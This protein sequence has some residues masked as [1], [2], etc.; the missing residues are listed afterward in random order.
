[1]I[2]SVCYYRGNDPLTH[3]IDGY[4]RYQQYCTKVSDPS[5]GLHGKVNPL[6]AVAFVV[7]SHEMN[8]TSVEYSIELFDCTFGER[9]GDLC[10][11]V[12]FLNRSHVADWLFNPCFAVLNKIIGIFL[13]LMCAKRTII[14]HLN[15]AY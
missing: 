10:D 5:H 15:V 4:R 8:S 11:H 7:I 6:V 13:L 2:I 14:S 9:P 1:M 12:V 3:P